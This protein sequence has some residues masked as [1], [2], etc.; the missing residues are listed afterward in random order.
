MAYEFAF[1]NWHIWS[2]NDGHNKGGPA[3][4]ETRKG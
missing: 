3:V 4:T 1:F 2:L